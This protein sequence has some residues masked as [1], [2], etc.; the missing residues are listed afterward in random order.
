MHTGTQT[1][2]SMIAQNMKQENNRLTNSQT[3]TVEKR[4]ERGGLPTIHTTV[5]CYL[6]V[7]AHTLTLT[8]LVRRFLSTLDCWLGL[9]LLALLGRR[10]LDLGRVEL[11]HQLHGEGGQ[12][13][14][15]RVCTKRKNRKLTVRCEK[16]GF[17]VSV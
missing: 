17:T 14:P 7:Q 11:V 2:W 5:Y 4:W 16:E 15:L 1:Q 13:G 8:H 9:Q 3:N 10:P 6:T 12:M